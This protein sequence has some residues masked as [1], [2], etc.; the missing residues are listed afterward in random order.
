MTMLRNV[1]LA[2]VSAAVLTGCGANDVASPGI[3]G[4]ITINNPPSNNPTPAPTPTPPPTVTAAAACPTIADPQG[5][6]DAGVTQATPTGTYRICQLPR[7]I[8]RSISLPKITGLV[9][10]IPARVDVGCDGGPV[11]PTAAAPYTST[12]LGC[13]TP[14]TAD[15]AVTLTIQ[16]GAILY[17]GSGLA[18]LGVNRGNQINAVGTREQPIIFT[19]RDNIAGINTDTSSGQWGGVVLLGRAQVTDCAT[20]GAA[21]GTIACERQ[22]EGVADPSLYGGATNTDNSGIMS[23]V[24]IRF[25][26]FPFAPDRE[27]QSLTTGGTGTGTRLSYIQSFNSS[28]DGA[29]FFGGRVN[30]KYLISVGAEDDNLDT[31]VG[32]KGNFQ[33]VIAVQRAGSNADTMI[34]ADSDNPADGNL[35]RQNVVVSNATFVQRNNNPTGGQASILLRGGTD[36]TLVNSVL[37]SNPL[38]P[39]L[40]IS[41]AQTASTVVDPA[42]DE[43][44]APVFRSVVFQCDATTKFIGSNSVTAAQVAAI[45]GSGT[46]NNNDAFVPTLTNAFV[47]GTAEAAVTPFNASGLNAVTG[48]PAFFDVTNYIGAV[49]DAADNWYRGWTCNSTTA[50]FGSGN[51]G[52]CTS[53]PTT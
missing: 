51:S 38:N 34:E 30:L 25:S 49:R 23:F 3:G 19:S 50:D 9:Y 16:P 46:N 11:A 33:Y 43:L 22:T 2:G 37:V 26:G 36:Y 35:P 48:G 31:D 4:N 13:T 20:P 41:R 1:L 10:E 15:T 17:G 8:R 32:V 42:I 29:E 12:T 52:L 7:V 39:C 21:P 28:D 14:L 44:G 18:F 40:R 27:L 24:Q 47:N 6:T 53:L 45:F 5:L